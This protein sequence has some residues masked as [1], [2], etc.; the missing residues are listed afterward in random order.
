[1][2][3]S[4]VI[5]SPVPLQPVGHVVLD[6]AGQVDDRQTALVVGVGHG[7]DVGEVVTGAGGG[8]QPRTAG[9]TDGGRDDHG[10]EGP[11]GQYPHDG[12][13]Q[14]GRGPPQQRR[15]GRGGAVHAGQGA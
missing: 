10:E 8:E 11:V 3:D 5:S 15:P 14:L 6:D 1:M 9:T 4:G 7:V 12:Q 13:L 2:V